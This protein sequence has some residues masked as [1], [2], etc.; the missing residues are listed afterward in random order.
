MKLRLSR[1]STE[2]PRP[3]ESIGSSLAIIGPVPRGLDVD[4]VLGCGTSERVIIPLVESPSLFDARGKMRQELVAGIAVARAILELLLKRSDE[5]TGRG[6][7]HALIGPE[8]L[9]G[10]EQCPE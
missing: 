5:E 8:Q 6:V 1:S 9:L 7:A 4:S 2:I 10:S 3:S